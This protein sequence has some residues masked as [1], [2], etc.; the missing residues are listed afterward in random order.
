MVCFRLSH[1]RVKER[2]RR[3]MAKLNERLAQ[4]WYLGPQGDERHATGGRLKPI[5]GR[6][7]RVM[8]LYLVEPIEVDEPDQSTFSG[9]R[10]HPAA[11]DPTVPCASIGSFFNPP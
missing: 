11:S 6:S 3:S 1:E 7:K 9:I 10:R 5:F 4:G 8:K 2:K